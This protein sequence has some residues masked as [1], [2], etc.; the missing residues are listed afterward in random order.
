MDELTAILISNVLKIF[1]VLAP[2]VAIYVINKRLERES[3]VRYRSIYF[4]IGLVFCLIH[5]V[6]RIAY[7]TLSRLI[8]LEISPVQDAVSL[9]TLF[10]GSL[11]LYW[12]VL[13]V[14][15]YQ[16]SE[17]AYKKFSELLPLLFIFSA[18]FVGIF[19]G[20]HPEND[21]FWALCRFSYLGYIFLALCYFELANF[22]KSFGSRQWYLAVIASCVLAVH[23]LILVHN[24]IRKLFGFVESTPPI[25]ILLPYI[26]GS[27]AGAL[28]LI[29][30]IALLL[31][32]RKPM[33]KIDKKVLENEYL[34]AMFEFLKNSTGIIGG[35]T[36]TIFRSAVDG[37][38]KRF[39]RDI[40][41]DDTIH[42]SGLSEDE[43][44]RFLEFLLNTYYQC[45]GPTL[46]ECTK[47]IKI[48]E[49]MVKKIEEKYA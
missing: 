32:M 23:P 7:R 41:I 10:V 25:F 37:F 39:S 17:S 1:I 30:S 14:K 33:P 3:K 8:E 12:F 35:A 31:E 9:L 44:P 19:W 36:M 38:N 34:T 48:L 47:G 49:D 18:F 11:F 5:V 21:L 26:F 13:L 40:R 45:I 28:I 2:F 29:P 43:W 6:W 15:E 46:F 22:L 16:T 27:I 24:Q 42:L 20:M 4:I